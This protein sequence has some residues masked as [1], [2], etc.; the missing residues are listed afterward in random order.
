MAAEGQNLAETIA[1]QPLA[2]EKITPKTCLRALR[3]A[4]RHGAIRILSH[5]ERALLKAAA[6]A[7]VTRFKNPI[8]KEKLAEI[9]VTIEMHTLKGKIFLTGLRRALISYYLV[10][11]TI[12]DILE[13]AKTKLSYILYLGRSI[14]ST[15][16]YFI[17]WSN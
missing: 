5:M 1:K 4:Y 9:I 8:I 10:S 7:R 16:N 11:F 2:P 14:L 13:W 6:N 12:N 17:I 3:R 15:R